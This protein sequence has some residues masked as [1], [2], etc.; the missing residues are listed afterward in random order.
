MD[1]NSLR[2]RPQAVLALTLTLL[3]LGCSASLET[4]SARIAP[5]LPGMGD[6]HFEITTSSAEAQQYFDQGLVL[7]YGFNHGEAARSFR[8]AIELDSECAMCHWGLSLVLG[9]NINS[10]MDPADLPEAYAAMNTAVGLAPAAT[11]REKAYVDALFERYRPDWQDDRSDLDGTYAEAM[12]AVY[13]GFP[14]DPDAGTR[15]V[16]FSRELYIEREDFME[17]PPRKF[18]RLAPGREVRLR[19]AYFVTCTE[20]VKDDA[21]RVTDLCPL[22]T[23]RVA[24]RERI[25][26]GEGYLVGFEPT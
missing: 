11:P 2:T 6:H 12:R 15:S 18:F 4:E 10:T 16:P 26:A 9:P 13:K 24:F 7:A 25:M 21:G 22:A 3:A 5:L 23:K 1:R 19:Y 8:Q 20:V 17:D 14:E